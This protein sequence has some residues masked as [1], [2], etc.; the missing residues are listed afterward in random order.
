MAQ[1]DRDKR[2][3][4]QKPSSTGN[5]QERAKP[6][7]PDSHEQSGSAG[8]RTGT[9]EAGQHKDSGQDRYGQSGAGG[10][11]RAEPRVQPD[12]EPARTADDEKV[13]SESRDGQS[14]AGSESDEYQRIQRAKAVGEDAPVD[15][16]SNPRKGE[17]SRSH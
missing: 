9:G 16:G 7:Q 11:Q 17:R 3:G 1:Q 5:G 2:S 4:S 15:G 12:P 6:V 14:S 10:T 8:R 13:V